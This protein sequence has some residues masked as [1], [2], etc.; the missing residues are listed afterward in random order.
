MYV[1]MYERFTSFVLSRR[2]TQE[3][4]SWTPG[5]SLGKL[6]TQAV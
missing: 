5:R 4:A 1:C 3:V 6:F 2:A